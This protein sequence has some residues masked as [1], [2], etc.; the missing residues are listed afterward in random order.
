MDKLVEES[1]ESREKPKKG[2][3]K[4]MDVL[5]KLINRRDA[6][7]KRMYYAQAKFDEE[8]DVN[9]PCTPTA[10]KWESKRNLSRAT[11]EAINLLIQIEERRRRLGL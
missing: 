3:S 10:Y 7:R 1:L 4:E 2:M 8:A 6:A 11:M 9:G 5:E